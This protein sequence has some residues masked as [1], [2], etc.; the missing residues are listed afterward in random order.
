MSLPKQIKDTFYID[1]P[2]PEFSY[3]HVSNIGKIII[4]KFYGSNILDSKKHIKL[5]KTFLKKYTLKGLILD[6]RY[7]VG[8][9]MWPTIYAFQDLL[10]NV[11]FQTWSSDG[12]SN[13]YLTITK[14]KTNGID[15]K[16]KIIPLTKDNNKINS[17]YPIAIIVGN[18]TSSSGEI[19]A[20]TFIGKS[21]VK[22]FGQKSSGYLTSNQNFTINKN[23]ELILTNKL[24][25]LTNGSFKEYIIPDKITKS[26]IAEAKKWIKA[27]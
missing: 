11:P 27:F 15:V 9:N 4:H 8:G 10:Y 1:R 26:P 13:K 18:Y 20:G 2:K 3:D 17:S 22:S 21:N 14:T 12:K 6:L 19:I 7:H 23:I 5:I 24:V 16:T 25:K